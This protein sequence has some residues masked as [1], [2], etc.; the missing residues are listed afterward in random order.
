MH[1]M[2]IL[3]THTEG[4]EQY[5]GRRRDGL[6]DWVTENYLEWEKEEFLSKEKWESEI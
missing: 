6:K 3:R 2:K 4:F 1:E 5:L